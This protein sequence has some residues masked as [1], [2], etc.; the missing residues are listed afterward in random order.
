MKAGAPV[1]QTGANHLTLQRSITCEQRSR[2][3]CNFLR[4]ISRIADLHKA[5]RIAICAKFGKGLKVLYVP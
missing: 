3:K 4:E 1:S 5:E 2:V